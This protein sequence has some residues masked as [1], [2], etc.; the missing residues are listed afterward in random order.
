MFSKLICDLKGNFSDDTPF[1]KKKV[2]EQIIASIEPN[3]DVIIPETSKGVEPLCAVYSK[4]CLKPIEKNLIEQKVKIR[5]FFE[6]VRV[7]TVS[8]NILRE[9]DPELSSFFNINTPGD[10]LLAKKNIL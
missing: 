7:R 5:Q 1:L 4:R 6:N 2:I 8:E 3:A 10:L 9:Y